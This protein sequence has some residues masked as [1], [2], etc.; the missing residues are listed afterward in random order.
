M[1]WRRRMGIPHIP[2]YNGP[3]QWG[4]TSRVGNDLRHLHEITSLWFER[5]IPWHSI[6]DWIRLW[7]GG[8]ERLGVAYTCWLKI[9]SHPAKTEN[10][11][12]ERIPENGAQKEYL[13]IITKRRRFG[14]VQERDDGQR[15][16]WG[17][18]EYSLINNLGTNQIPIWLS[19]NMG[20]RKGREIDV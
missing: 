6:T 19:P 2:R 17:G 12:T 9:W 13:S 11:Q 5:L 7:H 20:P 1:L 18:V 14:M 10:F 4:I 15:I 16:W 8:S 3:L